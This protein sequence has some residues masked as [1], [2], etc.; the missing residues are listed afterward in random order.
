MQHAP[1][2]RPA[3]EFV[4]GGCH[5]ATAKVAKGHAKWGAVARKIGLSL[6]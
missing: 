4:L 3:H 6:A 2:P 1:S 5:A